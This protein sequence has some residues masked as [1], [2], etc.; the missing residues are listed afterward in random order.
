MEEGLKIVEPIKYKWS[1]YL[2]GGGKN[3]LVWNC[4]EAPNFFWRCMQY[5]IFGNRWEKNN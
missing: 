1:C 5:I 3:D 2:F 4:N